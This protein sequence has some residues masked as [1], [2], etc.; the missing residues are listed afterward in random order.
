MFLADGS[1]ADIFHDKL[2]KG[3]LPNISKYL[4]EPGQAE[5][6]LTVFPSTTG[7]A[8]IPYLT[9]YHP[10]TVNVPGIRWFDRYHYAKH[11]WSFKSFRSYVG[12]ET[13]MIN[14]D[15]KPGTKTIFD[16]VDRPV[17]V[18]NN[19]GEI[20]PS[21]NKT[22]FSRIWYLYYAHL[23]DHWS[24][25]DQA[26]TQKVIKAIDEDFDFL[27]VVFPSIDEYAHRSSVI[28]PRVL[29]AYEDVDKQIGLVAA[30]LKEKGMLEDTLLTIVSDHGLSDTN[31][32]FDVGPYLEEN[33]LK[34]LF[35]TQIFKRNFKAS[36]MI[37]GNGMAHVYFKNEKGWQE[38]SYYE[39]LSLSSFWLD[40]FRH[41]P[42]VSLVTCEGRDGSVHFLT[43]KGH[44]L[45]QIQNNLIQYDW[46]HT[47]PLGLQLP[48]DHTGNSLKMTMDQ[49][50]DLT[51]DSHFPDVFNQMYSL[52]KSPRC[53]DVIL[54]AEKGSDLRKRYEHPEHKAS[55][56]AICPDHM[57]VPF[58]ISHKLSQKI[59]RSV[60]VFPTILELLG[61]KIP[62]GIDGV[63]KV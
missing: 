8:Y 2:A 13:Y 60:D 14:K 22:R 15:I 12:L 6:I 41:R 33:G 39:D 34:T 35:Y 47:E 61:K 30:K 54:S 44:G 51:W 18:L 19:I 16:L 63:S 56:G 17:S 4:V 48:S 38:K 7:A 58:I 1:R 29:Q 37:S 23:T 46:E 42:E 59:R 36:S 28:H 32:H 50:L 49:S 55:H 5:T 3:Q 27:F 52:F 43:K 45:F 24:F 31:Q 57:K 62:A 40:R 25:V 20:H 53:G 10:G 11:G 9:G 21:K 26:M